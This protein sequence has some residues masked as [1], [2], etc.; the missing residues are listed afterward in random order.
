MSYENNSVFYALGESL[1]KEGFCGSP[2]PRCV[3]GYYIFS[4]KVNGDIHEAPVSSTVEAMR[5]LMS[6]VRYEVQNPRH[7]Q[8]Y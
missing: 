1:D 5:D 4:Y 8:L 6:S 7:T 2:K 3:S